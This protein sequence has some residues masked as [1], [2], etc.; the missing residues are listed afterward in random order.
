MQKMKDVQ[1]C[2]DERG[3][4]IQKVGVSD[5]HLPFLIKT[6]AGGLQS[7]LARITLTVN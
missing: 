2:S 3:I 5:V 4:A 7:V 1:N 6:K